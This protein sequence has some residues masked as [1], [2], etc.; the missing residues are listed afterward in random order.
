LQGDHEVHLPARNITVDVRYSARKH[1]SHSQRVLIVKDVYHVFLCSEGKLYVRSKWWVITTQCFD[2]FFQTPSTRV[3]KL[4]SEL[5]MRWEI[6]VST[7]TV[8][9]YTL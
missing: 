5:G 8:S 2:T 9:S 3:L 1:W 7:F 4:I 6:T